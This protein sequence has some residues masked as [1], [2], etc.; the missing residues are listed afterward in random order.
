MT[1]SSSKITSV[2]LFQVISKLFQVCYLPGAQ[3]KDV[4]GRLPTLVQPSY[5]YPLLIFRVGSN[6][7]ALRSPKA[8]KRHFR[9]LRWQVKGSEAQV[10]FLSILPDAGN[11]EGTK[12]TTQQISTWLQAWCHW[13]S[14][15]VFDHGS[16]YMAP[17]LL[18]TDR[19][20]LSQRGK[21]IFA[22]ELAGLTE[23]AL[24]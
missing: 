15:G 24:N 9:V 10:V 18:A 20:H 1:P 14:F 8:M 13:Q 19:I 5:Y 4:K 17:G 12:R 23:R 16:A 2:Q 3:V 11:D 6:K 21:R 22:Q 7:V